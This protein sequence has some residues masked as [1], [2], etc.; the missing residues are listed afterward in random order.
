MH[1]SSPEGKRAFAAVYPWPMEI[2]IVCTGNICRSPM[3]EAMLRHFL[4]DRGV[5]GVSVSSS[6]TWGLDGEAATLTGVEELRSRGI[7]GS[8]HVARSLTLDQLD[9]ADLVIA[10][11]SV[12][13]REISDRDPTALR[14]TILLKE[15]ASL[16][17]TPKGATPAQRLDALLSGPR[18]KW[19]RA[20]DVDD[21][22]GL[23]AHAY[24]R[25]ADELYEGLGHLV[26][27]LWPLERSPAPNP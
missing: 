5:T 7:D 22:I 16:N 14:K 21:P 15:I 11:T 10:M 13:L 25:T 17:P 18:P 24:K 27:A 3:A 9:A 26:E 12:H 2:L 23:P 4:E 8:S 6:G 20:M 1:Q 19:V